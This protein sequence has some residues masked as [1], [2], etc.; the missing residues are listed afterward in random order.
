[1]R[2]MDHFQLAEQS[3]INDCFSDLQDT[4]CD[5]DVA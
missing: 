2:Q 4:I 1:M 5:E 3:N